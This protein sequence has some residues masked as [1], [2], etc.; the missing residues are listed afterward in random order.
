MSFLEVLSVLSVGPFVTFLGNPDILNSNKYFIY[1]YNYLNFSNENAFLIF[2]SL[3]V[4]IIMVI[5]AIVSMFTIWCLSMYGAK[6]GADLSNRLY[7]FYIHQPWIFHSVNNSSTLTNKISQECLRV[8]NTII[9]PLMFLNAKVAVIIFISLGII[10][11]N[12]LI[13]IFGLLIFSI[14]YFSIIGSHVSE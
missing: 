12:P 1:F 3:C 14:A 6:I 2:I 10:I 9:S 4:L 8:T 13:S 7:N 11:Y 5:S